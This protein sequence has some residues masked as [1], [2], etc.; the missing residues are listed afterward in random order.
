MKLENLAV[1]FIS[2]VKRP[3]NGRGV[4]LKC[5]AGAHAVRLTKADGRLKRLYGIVYAPDEMDAQGDWADAETI[6]KAADTWMQE[7]RARYVDREHEFEPVPA[8][9]AESWIIRSGDPLFPT[10]REGAW[11][12]GIQIEDAALWDAIEAGEVEGISLAGTAQM[13]KRGLLARLLHPKKG[14]RMTLEDVKAMV[15]QVLDE[16]AALAAADA[17]RERLAKSLADKDARIKTLEED[18][19][20]L[21]KAIER[22]E[23]EAEALKARPAGAPEGDAGTDKATSESFV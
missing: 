23:A 22:L 19:E 4:V 2:L 10:E 16:S 17:E 18:R 1:H 6:R 15:R 8:F 7:G 13:E 21:A 14:D 5:A 12:V 11:A 20:R 3:A 9:V